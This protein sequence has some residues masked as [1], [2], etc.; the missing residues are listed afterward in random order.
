MMRLPWAPCRRQQT[1]G[2]FAAPQVPI[3]PVAKMAGIVQEWK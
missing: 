3:F 1:G 2:L